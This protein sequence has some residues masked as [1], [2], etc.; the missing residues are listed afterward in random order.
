MYKTTVSAQTRATRRYLVLP[1]P[2]PEQRTIESILDEFD[3]LPQT[4]LTTKD[5]LRTTLTTFKSSIEKEVYGRE[6]TVYAT[7][8]RTG[9]K[10]GRTAAL[11]EAIVTLSA[12]K[13]G[14]GT[15]ND[16]LE[17]DPTDKEIA[18]ISGHDAAI[19]AAIKILT[20]L[21]EKV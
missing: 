1:P 15:A 21:K 19:N 10:E 9:R 20:N 7:G 5:W 17:Q 6:E 11:D 16:M 3:N 18:F 14:L 13:T 8:L 4:N 2:T 12:E